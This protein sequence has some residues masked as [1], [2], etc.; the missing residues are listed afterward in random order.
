[1]LPRVVKRGPQALMVKHQD[2][3][4]GNRFRASGGPS[5]YVFYQRCAQI[6]IAKMKENVSLPI[7]KMRAEIRELRE[8][9]DKLNERANHLTDLLELA[10]S[11]AEAEA[12]PKSK[13]GRPAVTVPP[14]ANLLGE[15]VSRYRDMGTKDA[16]IDYLR[17]KGK[18]A[19]ATEIS[20][21][22]IDGGKQTGSPQFNRT[23]D[24]TLIGAAKRKNAVVEKI[25]GEWALKEW[26]LSASAQ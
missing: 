21:A 15:A 17:R 22:L 9:A 26:H 6:G 18:P 23:V 13:R 8:Q 4:L 5:P 10:I 16:A 20:L 12:K 11:Y 14:R 25:E 24:N 19:G 7:S 3:T 1:M 2:V